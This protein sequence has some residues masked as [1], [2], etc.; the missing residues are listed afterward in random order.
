MQRMLQ[1]GLLNELPVDLMVLIHSVEGGCCWLADSPW[2]ETD[3]S[4]QTKGGRIEAPL[5]TEKHPC[6]RSESLFH[7]YRLCRLFG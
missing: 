3:C 1:C 6:S 4:V 2:Q 7:I 5:S